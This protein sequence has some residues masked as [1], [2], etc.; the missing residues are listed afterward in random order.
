MNTLT[1]E[2]YVAG[3]ATEAEVAEIEASPSLMAQVAE[4]RI[5]NAALM[6][7][8]PPAAVAERVQGRGWKSNDARRCS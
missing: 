3:C 8:L 7:S 5:E 4:M 2:R 6:A 1:L